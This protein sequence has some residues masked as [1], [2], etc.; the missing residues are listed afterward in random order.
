MSG[1]PHSWST[2]STDVDDGPLD[3]PDQTDQTARVRTGYN[4]VSRAYRGD[5][6]TR[7]PNC[8]MPGG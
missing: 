8:S 2:T 4:V 6:L 1:W 5:T 7:R 3:Q